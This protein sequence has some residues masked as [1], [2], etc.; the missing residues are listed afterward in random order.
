M[1]WVRM[2][3]MKPKTGRGA[4]VDQLLTELADYF[5]EQDG[6][7]EGYLLRAKDGLVGRVTVW[8]T[9]ASADHSAQSNHVMSVRSRLNPDVEEGSHEEHAF[10]GMHF[11]RM[12]EK[13]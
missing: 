11:A 13:S 3:L 12:T 9:E 2:S 6:F 1:P 7:L 8:E 5:A 10:E 4:E